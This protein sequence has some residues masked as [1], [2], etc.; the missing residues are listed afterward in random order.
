[1]QSEATKRPPEADTIDLSVPTERSFEPVIRLVLGGI[2]DRLGL[3][4]EDLDDLQLAVERVVAEASSQETLNVSFEI[5]ETSVRTHV[6]PL[7]ERV[8]AEALQRPEPPPGEL[9]L[10]RILEAVVDSFGVEET[11]RGDLIVR[12]EKLI[13]VA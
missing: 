8:L 10:R 3:S 9:T 5:T 11:N 4:L 1:M 7:R 13:T 12:L 6:G 2:A